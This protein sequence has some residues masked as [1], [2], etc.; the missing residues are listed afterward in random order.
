MTKFDLT[1]RALIET[2]LGAAG[3]AVLAKEDTNG[4]ML[5]AQ[6][7]F[8]V[9]VRNRTIFTNTAVHSMDFFFRSRAVP[10]LLFSRY[11]CHIVVLPSLIEREACLHRASSLLHFLP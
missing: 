2:L 6:R 7:P 9:L 8:K 3:H 11:R 10:T 1:G 5:K 4:S